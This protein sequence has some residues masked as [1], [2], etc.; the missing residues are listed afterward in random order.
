[1]LRV[2]AS[3][4]GWISS[5]STAILASIHDFEAV[6]RVDS[7]NRFDR[8]FA[9]R[10]GFRGSDHFFCDAEGESLEEDSND[11][12]FLEGV[13]LA[14]IAVVHVSLFLDKVL[15]CFPLDEGECEGRLT[16]PG[17]EGWDPFIKA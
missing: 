10:A 13:E 12:M 15:Y 1:L 9:E 7:F 17:V 16:M 2:R 14:W 11:R 8:V 4:G 6:V 5:G 3:R